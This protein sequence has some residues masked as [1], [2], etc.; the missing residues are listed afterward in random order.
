[1]VNLKSVSLIASVDRDW[2]IGLNGNLCL[3]V[4]G[5]LRYFK[6]RTIGSIVVMGRKTYESI[7][8][9]LSGRTNV[10]LTSDKDFKIFG[11][12]V[13]HSKEEVIK[14]INNTDKDVFI[15]GG[16]SVYREFLPICEFAYITENNISVEHDRVF[17]ERLDKSDD[18]QLIDV[19]RNTTCTDFE[20]NFCI[21]RRRMVT[22]Q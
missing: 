10:I 13:L 12:T 16:E 11:T 7:K 20:S 6:G 1:M 18:W 4:P 8:Y 17:P 9:P 5:D 3:N 2:G 21:Y 15:I 19:I 22:K 14:F